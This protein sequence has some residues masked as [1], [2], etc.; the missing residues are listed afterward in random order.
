[1]KLMPKGYARAV[2]DFV[3]GGGII[4]WGIVP[5]DSEG[6][7]RETPQTLADLLAGY[8]EVVSME[9]GLPC[10]QIAEQALLA[11]ARCCLKNVGRAGAA[12]ESATS[13]AGDSVSQTAEELLVERAFGYLKSLSEILKGKFHL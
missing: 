7:D 13:P 3:T 6:I 2:A 8:W 10:R 4:C 9:T 1:M 12:G 5:T 11:P